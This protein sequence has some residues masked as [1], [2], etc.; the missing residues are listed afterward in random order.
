ME[1]P[2]IV[3]PPSADSLDYFT[4][5]S[6][7]GCWITTGYRIE[8]IA[9]EYGWVWFAA[10]VNIMCYA[11]IAL[12]LKG[13]RVLY[14]KGLPHRYLVGIVLVDGYKI[15]LRRRSDASS[16]DS[17]IDGKIGMSHSIQ[18]S[19]A[20]AMQML[21][22]VLS[23]FSYTCSNGPSQL[24]CRIPRCDLSHVPC[25]MALFLWYSSSLYRH[26]LCQYSIL[27]IRCP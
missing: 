20:I 4:S 24:P 1:I 5:H 18:Q 16:V 13:M 10:C 27:V 15:R 26:S 22:W 3:C 17:D 14:S 21:L 25:P 2:I 8:Q 9:L 23:I 6:F 12:V 11:M 19:N 7:I